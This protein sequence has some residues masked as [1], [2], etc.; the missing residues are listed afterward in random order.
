MHGD[1]Y[2]HNILHCGQGRALLGDFGAASFYARDDGTLAPLLERIEVRAFGCL[3]EEL[4][5]RID[6]R[7]AE[8]DTLAAL[9]RLQAACFSTTVAARPSFEEIVEGLSA[10]SGSQGSLGA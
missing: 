8:P 6:K 3:L 2:A 1:L 7:E 10:L 4:I 5:E 9:L